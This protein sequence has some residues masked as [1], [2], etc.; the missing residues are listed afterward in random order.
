MD[1]PK[2]ITPCVP[3]ICLRLLVI[4]YSTRRHTL[5]YCISGRIISGS[6]AER[7][8]KLHVGD[9]ILAVNHIDITSLHHGEIVNLIKEAGY[10]VVLTIGPPTG[11]ETNSLNM[12]KFCF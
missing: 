4:I 10:S 2:N 5:W 3:D 12:E 11:M 9:R 1:I 6:P 8:E 7:C